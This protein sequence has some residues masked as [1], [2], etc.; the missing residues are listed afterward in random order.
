MT[1]YSSNDGPV[2]GRWLPPTP[3]SSAPFDQEAEDDREIN[4]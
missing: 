4:K 1:K 3:P 2:K